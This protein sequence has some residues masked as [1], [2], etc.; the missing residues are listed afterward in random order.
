MT[1]GPTVNNIHKAT[2]SGF[3][4]EWA[5]FDQRALPQGEAREIF[6]SYFS[7]VDW[8]TLPVGSIAL[9]VGCGSGRWAA[10]VAQ[11]VGRLHLIDASPLALSVA[12][13]NLSEF[14]NCE[15]HESSV[16]EIPLP[17]G[18]AD[19]VYSLGVL[20]HVP[21][22][23]LAIYAAVKK[24]KVGGI[25]LVYLY[26][27]FDNRPLWFSWLWRIS[28]QLRR[29][30]SSLPFRIRAIA[31][32]LLAVGVYFPFASLAKLLERTGKDVSSF[33]LSFY[34]D[35]SFY[36]MRTDALD[37]FGTKL[38]Q[39]FTKEEILAML[40]IAGLTDIRFRE[41]EPFWCATGVRNG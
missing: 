6:E 16:D 11:R 15:F 9:D 2:V 31:A 21:D 24:L 38:E 35:K 33:P 10:Q 26:Y 3:G 29:L 4:E 7:L 20:H 8:S 39:R 14:T 32:D 37:R 18:S 5:K 23:S 19:L 17:D 30:V 25:F 34:R 40:Q 36:T 41:S 12:R 1:S 22:T 27:R 28:D 13:L